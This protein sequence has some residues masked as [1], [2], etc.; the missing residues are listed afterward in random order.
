[1][2]VIVFAAQVHLRDMDY[3]TWW[4]ASM[5][6]AVQ[7]AAPNYSEMVMK[8]YEVKEY[9]TSDNLLEVVDLA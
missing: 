7:C 2:N 9:H 3:V 1:M 8:R 5:S 4:W 6:K